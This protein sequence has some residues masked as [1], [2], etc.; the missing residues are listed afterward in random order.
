MDTNSIALFDL[1]R[2]VVTFAN[3]DDHI[4]FRHH[5]YTK[6]DKGKNIELKEIG[7]RFQLK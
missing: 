6:A 2:R 5:T 7:P 4:S 1:F 3:H